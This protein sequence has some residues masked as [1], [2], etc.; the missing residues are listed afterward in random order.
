ML[1]EFPAPAAEAEA[2]APAAPPA[3]AD[4]AT[5][6]A[7]ALAR[8]LM[9][10]REL[11]DQTRAEFERSGQ[12]CRAAGTESGRAL[13]EVGRATRNQDELLGRGRSDL[14]QS[15]VKQ[16]EALRLEN[17]W[18]LVAAGG[19]GAA[20]LLAAWLLAQLLG[21]P[22]RRAR[23]FALSLT[24]GDFER[25]LPAGRGETGELSG[26]LNDLAGGLARQAELARH[27][28]AGD[29]TEGDDAVVVASGAS[30]DSLGQSLRLL[31]GSLRSFVGRAIHGV[32]GTLEQA[33][34]LDAAA[35]ELSAGA[36]QQAAGLEEVS[37]SLPSIGAQTRRNAEHAAEADRFTAAVRDQAGR[38]NELM[39]SLV[40]AMDEIRAA[41]RQVSEIV[42]VLDA[43]ARKTRLLALNA[44]IEAERAGAAGESFAVVAQEVKDLAGHSAGQAKAIAGLIQATAEKVESGGQLADQTAQALREII[45]GA[46]SAADLAADIARDSQ[47][48]AQALDQASSG[49]TQIETIT[50][51]NHQAAESTAAAARELRTQAGE[52]QQLL[53]RFRVPETVHSHPEQLP[54]AAAAAGLA[55]PA[56]PAR[57]PEPAPTAPPTSQSPRLAAETRPILASPPPPAPP[58]PASTERPAATAASRQAAEK[59]IPLEVK[60]PL[61]DDSLDDREFG[62][63]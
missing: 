3:E 36:A 43:I 44:T 26:A 41:S 1:K 11:S 61:P 58:R 19:L 29:L 63:Y 57:L 62:K 33:A 6:A 35:R 56:G 51:H 60:E 18:T 28:S 16:A 15:G 20:A 49:L 45:S 17:R 34:R 14:E 25:R 42:R 5:G 40:T 23:S 22:L 10:G 30:A 39:G 27:I 46:V 2:P 8:E 13:A 38:G 53:A 7:A 59:L 52:L 50:Q 48:Q 31:V 55:A 21:A 24:A 32:S 4:P 12:L 54:A 47:D 9:A 37:S